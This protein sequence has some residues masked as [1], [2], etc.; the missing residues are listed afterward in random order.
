MLLMKAYIFII[1]NILISK[2][3]IVVKFI[4]TLLFLLT[5]EIIPKN[6]VY[7]GLLAIIS[8]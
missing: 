3:K 5:I 2:Y 1:R 6:N 7:S 8:K 4:K